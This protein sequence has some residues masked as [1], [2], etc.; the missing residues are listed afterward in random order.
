MPRAVVPDDR[1]S[2]RT[3]RCTPTGQGDGEWDTK[4]CSLTQ[5]DGVAMPKAGG[6]KVYGGGGLGQGGVK[7]PRR[8]GGGKQVRR[9]G[10][11]DQTVRMTI[12]TEGAG[13]KFC[14]WPPHDPSPPRPPKK[15]TP[16]Y[17]PQN[18]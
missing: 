14:Q 1:L 15:K 7:A 18:D 12:G 5:T 16:I 4:R 17:T 10:S 2:E 13:R 11:N 9:S 8:R 6:N 3:E